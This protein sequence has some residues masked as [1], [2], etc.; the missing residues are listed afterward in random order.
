MRAS[1][2]TTVELG[3]SV[4]PMCTAFLAFPRQPRP[5]PPFF[6]RVPIGTPVH[7]AVV[8]LVCCFNHLH[9]L[10]ILCKRG[11][12][13]IFAI[14]LHH[15]L[16]R[17]CYFLLYVSELDILVNRYLWTCICSYKWCVNSQGHGKTC[18]M[19]MNTLIVVVA[20]G[21]TVVA[22]VVVVVEVCA[23]NINIGVH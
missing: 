10:T 22:A 13:S 16:C 23:I 11:K 18:P 14:F 19:L 2:K 15:A 6:L 4:L 5:G 21:I 8:V 3:C 7:R 20:E 9:G 1:I 12:E 17:Q